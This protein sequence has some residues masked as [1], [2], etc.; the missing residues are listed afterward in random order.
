MSNQ[1]KKKP[2]AK[3][4]KSRPY[5]NLMLV[6]INGNPLTK[7]EIASLLKWDAPRGSKKKGPKIYNVSSY[8]W[9]IKNIPQVEG[10]SIVV[11]SIRDGKKVT[12]YQI[13]NVDD[14]KAYLKGRG[15]YKEAVVASTSPAAAAEASKQKATEAAN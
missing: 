5:E 8:V 6:L 7:E 10:R 13:V 3:V 12:A 15:L 11:R 9:D 14:A 2:V 4:K 1:P